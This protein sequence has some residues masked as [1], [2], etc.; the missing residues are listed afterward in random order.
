[1]ARLA[2]SGALTAVYV[3]Q[4]E[5]A[6]IRDLTRTREDALSDLKDP[7]CRRK[8][9]VLRHPIRYAGQAH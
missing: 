8:A 2:R 1:L 6:A 5:D 3:P 4:V 9:F 7:K